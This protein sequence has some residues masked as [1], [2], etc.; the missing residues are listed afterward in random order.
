MRV[1]SMREES[2]K[3]VVDITPTASVWELNLVVSLLN[4]HP[5]IH[6]FS[7]LFLCCRSGMHREYD[8]FQDLRN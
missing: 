3:H 8:V 5:T 7:N 4:G 6:N 2:E 1:L